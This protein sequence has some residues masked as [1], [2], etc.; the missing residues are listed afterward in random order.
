MKYQFAIIELTEIPVEAYTAKS[1]PSSGVYRSATN[2][3]HL[4]FVDQDYNTVN[5]V[6]GRWTE[7]LDK[8]TDTDSKP[9]IAEE[10]V[11]RLIAAANGR[12]L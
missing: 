10:I 1:Y 2:R 11:L 6:Y 12:L 4:Y 7:Y 8:V 5:T 9:V 3:S